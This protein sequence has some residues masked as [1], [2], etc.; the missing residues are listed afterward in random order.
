MV[1]TFQ[2][3]R[4]SE[5]KQYWSASFCINRDNFLC[6]LFQCFAACGLV[7]GLSCPKGQFHSSVSRRC[8]NL[9]PVGHFMSKE[10][11]TSANDTQC[12]PCRSGTY[13]AKEN[14]D[15]ACRSC[16][17]S[18]RDQKKTIVKNCSLASDIQCKCSDN[19]YQDPHSLQCRKCT[20]CIKKD[21]VL[22]SRCEENK[23]AVCKACGKVRQ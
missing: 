20:S 13:N 14:K 6:I 1:V 12:L 16:R 19:F 22:V 7:C 3:L 15:T 2:L 11:Q 8:C 18:C 21:Q 17:T 5:R 4:T 9:C 23:D 10:C